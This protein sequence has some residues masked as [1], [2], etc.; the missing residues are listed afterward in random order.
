M[1]RSRTRS[2]WDR[3]AREDA[4]YFVDNRLRY[5]R[6]DKERFWSEGERDLDRLL[7][8]VGVSIQSSDSVLEIGCGVGRLTRAIAARAAMVTALDVSP[9]MLEVA[10]TENPTLSNVAWVLGDGTSLAG[11]A[12]SSVD[13]CV[14]H[15]V[16]QHLPDP[17][18]TLGYVREMG[19]VLRPGGWSAFQF[20]NDPDPHRPPPARARLRLR[21]RALVRVGPGG[22]LVPSWRGS[23][24]S[25]R[26][27]HEAA[28][29]G[30]LRIGRTVGE[31]SQFCLALAVRE[32]ALPGG[33]GG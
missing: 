17:E 18:V 29:Q 32:P 9:R 7:G 6:P 14:S 23:A 20:S 5:R 19:R 8:A 33:M 15:V 3:R 30:G 16:F 13:V 24:V 21:L 25:L 4:F 28:V 10:R 11:M 26:D 31:G 12:D 27:L 1:R 22:Q 2:F